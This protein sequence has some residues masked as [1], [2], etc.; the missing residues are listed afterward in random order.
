[1][2]EVAEDEKPDSLPEMYK[3]ENMMVESKLP[4]GVEQMKVCYS[5]SAPMPNKASYSGHEDILEE[6]R[7]LSK[8]MDRFAPDESMSLGFDDVPES[9][10]IK[11]QMKIDSLWQS[12]DASNYEIYL[13]YLND[14]Y[15]S[16]HRLPRKKSE[17]MRAGFDSEMIH[18][19]D[20]KQFRKEIMA[21]AI[22]LYLVC[23]DHSA[24]DD[25][26]IKYLENK[27]YTKDGVIQKVSNFLKQLF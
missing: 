7:F 11:R 13:K 23:D 26:F 14:W 20:E 18:A 4:Q 21:F 27:Y 12:V 15:V 10:T 3:V 6:P 9:R 5:M 2:D 17:L 22:K 1:V 8:R 19:F 16:Y 24:L 25:S